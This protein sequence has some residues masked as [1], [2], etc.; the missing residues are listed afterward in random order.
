ML[1]PHLYFRLLF[2]VAFLRDHGRARM[3]EAAHASEIATLYLVLLV[4]IGIT[5][6]PYAVCN[7]AKALH[8]GLYILSN[9]PGIV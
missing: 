7:V 1:S 8:S 9:S 4:A 3:A 6:R 5:F 2:L